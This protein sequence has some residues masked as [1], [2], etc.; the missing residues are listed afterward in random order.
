MTRRLVA[1]RSGKLERRKRQRECWL[2]QC[3]LGAVLC[4]TNPLHSV[5]RVVLVDATLLSCRLSPC[6]KLDLDAGDE[7]PDASL[8]SPLVC[9]LREQPP[10]NPVMFF[11]IVNRIGRN[12]LHKK[13]EVRCHRF[14]TPAFSAFLYKL[15]GFWLIMPSHLYLVI[16]KNSAAITATAHPCLPLGTCSISNG[17]T[18]NNLSA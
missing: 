3:V 1:R 4:I 16:K 8:A 12:N 15:G 2:R 17:N 13:C 10:K 18:I 7:P 11:D 14:S 6:P 5:R 9:P